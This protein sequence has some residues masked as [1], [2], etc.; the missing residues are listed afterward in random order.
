MAHCC[1]M[2]EIRKF[3]SENSILLRVT[4]LKSKGVE[5]ARNWA[6]DD[7]NVVQGSVPLVALSHV[8]LH[9]L[10]SALHVPTKYPSVSNLHSNLY[11]N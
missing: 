3:L 11:I 2:D 7:N 9:H 5:A 10:E 8:Q 6:K 1:Q 4:L